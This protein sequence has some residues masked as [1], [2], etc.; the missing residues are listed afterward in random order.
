MRYVDR[1]IAVACANNHR[2]V[3]RKVLQQSGLDVNWA[4]PVIQCT[5][6]FFA[7]NLG[8]SECLTMIIR[9]GGVDLSKMESAGQAPIHAAC[10][11]GRIA[12]LFILLD[13]GV[14]VNVRTANASGLT[15]VMICCVYGHVK[16]LALLL[17]R[18][19]DPDLADVT[20]FTSAH[21]ACMMG[22]IKCLQLLIA[23]RANINVRAVDGATPLDLARMC[24]HAE[25]VD[26]LLENHAVGV[27]VEH[28]C[29]PTEAM[30]VRPRSSFC[31]P[32]MLLQQPC[33]HLHRE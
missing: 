9:Y 25:C 18:K 2:E 10:K 11:K 31:L 23:R 6:A 20:G 7:A 12:C 8:H 15:P 33:E 17:D 21:Y 14:G 28:I 26:L 29:T 3:L 5:A 16:C 19:A 30:K 27:R 1:D 4:D 32:V 24:G 22:E 13:N